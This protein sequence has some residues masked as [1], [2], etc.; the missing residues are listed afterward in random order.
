MKILKGIVLALALAGLSL[1]A[2]AGLHVE[3]FL[4]YHMGKDDSTPENDI[5]GTEMGARVGFSTLGLSVGGELSKGMYDVDSNPS[6]DLEPTN[7]G[8][9]AAFEFPILVRAYATYIINAKA[10]YG[11]STEIEGSGVRL[12][13][14]FTG[15]PFIAINVEYIDTTY[16]ECS[17]SVACVGWSD[18]KSKLYGINV[19]LP[20]DLL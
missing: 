5:T 16:D 2:Q 10:D 14:G 4:G 11:S 12:G 8:I 6:V 1:P 20:L 15:L 9:F 19:S 17:G 18:Y 3:P 7:M 13:V